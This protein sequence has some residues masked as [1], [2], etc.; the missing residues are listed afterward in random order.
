MKSEAAL[1]DLEQTVFYALE[2]TIKSYRQ[3]AQRNIDQH[4]LKITIDQ[5]LVL[6][7]IKD[8]PGLLQ[9]EIAQRVFKDLAS[10]TRMI[11]LLV[12]KDY[13]KRSFHEK[14]RRRYKLDLTQKGN[15][16]YEQLVPIILNNRATALTDITTD[17]I[18]TLHHLLQKITGNCH[19]E[20]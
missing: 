6:K 7:T 9:K 3:F 18:N 5:W 12:K 20:S 17:D 14:D 13:L 2:K 11:E 15:K 8:H 19:S 10:V 4:D 16:V 1:K